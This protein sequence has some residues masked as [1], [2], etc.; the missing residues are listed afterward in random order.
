MLRRSLPF[1]GRQVAM[2]AAFLVALFLQAGHAPAIAAIGNDAN[3]RIADFPSTFIDVKVA[4]DVNGDGRADLIVSGYTGHT[5]VVFGQSSNATVSL[6]NLGSNGFE[7]TGSGT[8]AVS[9]GDVNGD[10]RSDVLVENVPSASTQTSTAWVV[11]GKSSYA[12]V[13]LSQLGQGGFV[14]E[15]IDR[16]GAQ[17]RY[18]KPSDG[19]GDLNNDGL[20]DLVFGAPGADYGGTNSGSAYVVFGK[21]STDAIN[22]QALGEQGYRIDG[23]S[24]SGAGYGVARAG[25]VNNDGRADILMT[26]PAQTGS[27]IHVVFGKSSTTNLSLTDLGP[28]GY[29][30]SDPGLLAADG[31]GDTNGDGF[32]D[33]LISG[34][35]V[36]YVIYGK[37]ST[38]PVTASQAASTSGGFSIA[39][40][41]DRGYTGLRGTPVLGGAGDVNNDGLDDVLLGFPDATLN[42]G[43][44][45]S[46]VLV[47]GKSVPT[48]VDLCTGGG[49]GSRFD[50]SVTPQNQYE[51]V[52][53]ESL[54]WGVAGADVN[55]DGQSD[56]IAAADPSPTPGLPTKG[57]YVV[58]GR[59]FAGLPACPPDYQLLLQKYVPLLAYD[60][61]EVYKADSANTITDNYVSGAY[62]NYLQ[63]A[64]V[65][66][67]S[68]NPVIL[69]ASNPSLGYPRLSLSFLGVNYSNGQ[70]AVG[71]PG[72][73]YMDEA[74]TYSVDAQR[75]HQSTTYRDKIYG[76]IRLAPDGS[77]WLQYWFFYYYNEGETILNL[78]A[79]EAD[80]EMIQIGLDSSGS[81]V[82]ATYA[83][84][85]GGQSCPW[86]AVPRV[87]SPDGEY[88]IVFVGKGQHPSEF[89]PGL[90]H[91]GGENVRPQMTRISGAT[92]WALW[93][94]RWGASD[95]VIRSP[96]KQG[97]KWDDPP[98]FDASADDCYTGGGSS[99]MSFRQRSVRQVSRAVRE[100]ARLRPVR[101]A[102]PVIRASRVGNRAV[103][104]YRF[105]D[106]LRRKN[107]RPRELWITVHSATTKNLPSGGPYRIS[108][109]RGRRTVRLP[110][111]PGPYVVRASAR[112]RTGAQ[113]SV[114]E[115]PLRRK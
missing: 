38:T 113:S 78:G 30:I 61:Q 50:G 82:V 35:G 55:G 105:K 53:G 39:A 67:A 108:K 75:M 103:V 88:P 11:F 81:P 19:L 42:N 68:G 58:F 112:V 87:T 111:G 52:F 48:S 17:I 21:A 106:G 37:S 27:G 86:S 9:A 94:G 44:G 23:P 49:A 1:Q 71:P 47:Y 25:D 32:A 76:H 12:A 62:S 77:V 10:G 41:T 6:T 101:V 64:D 3:I 70:V 7:I 93:P 92:S 51:Q 59:A 66:D 22:V 31:A 102:A 69:A 79:H 57:A 26:G 20:S 85:T 99:S 13:D 46:V 90:G 65:L 14:I 18:H 16:S 107:R 72:G 109:L 91:V 45:G 95:D 60:I 104:R 96:A 15:G 89:Q 40:G 4:R 33:T 97:N 80:W 83:Q 114:V 43:S 74:N 34:A 54:G 98:A 110:L 73:H 84:H 2:L 115:V 24:G 5:Y 36:N 28:N 29:V 8:R 63:N 56:V 100:L